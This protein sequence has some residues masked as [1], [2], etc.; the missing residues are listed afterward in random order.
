MSGGDLSGIRS[1]LQRGIVF[2]LWLCGVVGGGVVVEYLILRI[3]LDH[4]AVDYTE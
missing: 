2:Q 3:S 4:T 1:G